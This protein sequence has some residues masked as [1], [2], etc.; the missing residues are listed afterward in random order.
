MAPDR[1]EVLAADERVLRRV[2]HV[3]L[4]ADEARRRRVAGHQQVPRVVVLQRREDDPR[5]ADDEDGRVGEATRG[6][7]SRNRPGAPRQRRQ[8]STSVAASAIACRISSVSFS[9]LGTEEYRSSG[10]IVAASPGVPGASVASSATCGASA[11]DRDEDLAVA[12]QRRRRAVG[13]ERGRCT[14]SAGGPRRARVAPSLVTVTRPPELET[15]S[16][17]PGVPAETGS[18]RSASP[19]PRRA[20]HGTSALMD[21]GRYGRERDARRRRGLARLRPADDGIVGGDRA[22]TGSRCRARS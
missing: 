19:P 1:H 12:G 3:D 22:R 11:G 18:V 16:P 2:E 20:A 8:A 13:D 14:A 5:G 4:V 15:V 9:A 6:R 21:S 7:R 10:W 17:R